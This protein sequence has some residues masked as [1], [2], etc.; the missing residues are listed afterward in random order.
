MALS[1]DFF[2]LTDSLYTDSACLVEW[3]F[4]KS[5]AVFECTVFVMIEELVLEW[6]V[7]GVSKFQEDT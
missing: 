1:A 7:G 6:G 4:P 5:K 3:L 2:F